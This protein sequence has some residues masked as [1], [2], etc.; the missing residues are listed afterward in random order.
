MTIPTQPQRHGVRPRPRGRFK[1]GP[2]HLTPRLELRNAGVD[3]NVFNSQ[4]N[5]V[6]DTSVVLRPSV[7]AVL[8][9]GRRLRVTGGAYL[10][11]NYYRRFT[12]ERS[13]DFGGE[14]LAELE[15]GPL[16]LFG[17]AGG[18]Q[19]KQR[20]S[21]DVDQ[22]VLRQERWLAAG[23]V[24]GVGPR[25]SFT[26]SAGER[27]SR[28]GNLLVGGSSVADQLDRSERTAAVQGR[29]ALTRQTTVLASAEAIEDLFLRQR[30]GTRV[31][32]SWRYLGGLEFGDTGLL[33]G[34][35]L[36]GVRR[37]P[38]SRPGAVPPY[39][40]LAASVTTGLS[41]FGQGRLTVQ[42][43]RD[44]S[45]AAVPTSAASES[46]RNSYVRT[47]YGTDAVVGLP[48]NLIGRSF[49]SFEQARYIR[50]YPHGASF[51][52]RVD[53]QWTVGGSLLLRVSDGLRLGG[54]VAWSRR[55]SNFEGAS[56]QGLRYGL[57]GEL[58]P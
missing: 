2:L 22:R 27:V 49:A 18:G 13:T 1:V 40:G 31:A 53:H 28:F 47:R 55:R 42:A 15:V 17:G 11:L 16:V 5:P 43:E 23:V 41:L 10:D 14:G 34:R 52:P 35:V 8:P 7:D 25:I 54:T 4:T 33:S 26:G 56:Y 12:S 19:G 44:V 46:L 24:L 51:A 38:T 20:F 45:Y 21:I 58:V 50:P 32:H 39:S 6:P 57:Q 48:L 9:Y 29:F 37:F 30:E 3:T 36:L